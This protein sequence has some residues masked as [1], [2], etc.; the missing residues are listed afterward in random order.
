MRTYFGKVDFMNR[1]I[2]LIL[3]LSLGMSSFLFWSVNT[4]ASEEIP[5]YS[6]EASVQLNNN[7][8]DF[9]KDE[10]TTSSFESYGNLDKRGRCTTATA[11]IGQDLMPTEERQ[12]IVDVR[13]TGWKQ[14]KYPGLVDS[15]PPYLYNR[16]HLIAFQLAGENAKEKNLI[17]GTRYMNVDGMLPYE[18]EVSDYVRRTGNHVMYRVT[19]VFTGR[20]LLCDGVQIEAYSVEDK[21]KGVSFNVFCYNV[22]TGILIDYRDGSNKIDPDYKKPVSADDFVIF[23]DDTGTA[24]DRSAPA[25][26]DEVTYVLNTNT[27]KFHNPSC[28]SVKDMS[29]KNREYTNRSREEIIAD[30][31]KPCKICNP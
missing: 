1:A 31:Y 23:G 8:P 22:Q 3:T 19:P 5:A 18:F 4:H 6:G 7:V 14:N 20:N 2:A 13:P 27:R 30:G 16:C 17:T 25:Q 21:G 10:I 28:G 26:T 9:S 11:C 15:D 12:S 29:E 24:S